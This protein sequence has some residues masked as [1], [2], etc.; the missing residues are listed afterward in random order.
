MAKTSKLTA[1]I[2]PVYQPLLDDLLA[3]FEGGSIKPGEWLLGEN[4]LSRQ[5]G[6]GHISVRKALSMLEQQG[7][8]RRIRGRGTQVL[9][10][11][12]SLSEILVLSLKPKAVADISE[13]KLYLPVINRVRKLGAAE[14]IITKLVYHDWLEDVDPQ[15]YWASFNF[16][17]DTG[18]MLI[19]ETEESCL[20]AL[21]DI[22]GP[23]VQVDHR[24]PG[25]KIDSVEPDNAAC[26]RNMV[27]H[28]AGL[29]HRKLIYLSWYKEKELNPRRLEGVFEGLEKA[30]IPELAVPPVLCSIGTGDGFTKS[31]YDALRELL[32][33]KASFTGIMANNAGFAEEAIRALTDAGL[34]VPEDVSVVCVSSRVVSD[35]RGRPLT[36]V[37]VDMERLADEALHRLLYRFKNRGEPDREIA[38]P[39]RLVPGATCMPVNKDASA[40]QR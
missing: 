20:P 6:I 34:R 18:V 11:K 24:I 4:K 36:Y 37:D 2:Q 39:V 27:E 28:L 3:A 25:L 40:L 33:N 14:D 21:S 26:G 5:Y 10:R 29:G 12:S 19:G 13:N 30:G 38:V 15:A 9:E 32:K 8:I 1:D 35:Q 7:Y 22:Q 16:K 17:P 23:V 31:A